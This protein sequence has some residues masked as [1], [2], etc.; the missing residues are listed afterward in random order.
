MSFFFVG[1]KDFCYDFFAFLHEFSDVSDA[2]RS[3]FRD[4]YHSGSAAVF[5][6]RAED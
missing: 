2:S 6:E 3:Y 4:V 5:I 1:L